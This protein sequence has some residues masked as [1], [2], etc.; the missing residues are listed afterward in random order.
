MLV[1]YYKNKDLSYASRKRFL[2]FGFVPFNQE[3]QKS[4]LLG[5]GANTQIKTKKSNICD[6]VTIDNTRWFVTSYVYCNGGQVIMYLQRDVIGEMGI[7]DC[8]GKIERGY[9]ES[10]LRNRKELSLNQILKERKKL[11]PDSNKYGEYYVDNHKNEMWGIL[12]FVKGNGE[13]TTVN[14]PSFAPKPLSYDFIENGTVKI[15][16][17]N[18]ADAYI[19]FKVH[20]SDTFTDY[21]YSVNLAFNINKETKE[22]YFTR[23]V[24]SIGSGDYVAIDLTVNVKLGTLANNLKL[25]GCRKIVEHYADFIGNKVLSAGYGVSFKLPDTKGYNVGYDALDYDGVI[26]KHD[27]KYLKYTTEKF[28]EYEYGSTSSDKNDFIANVFLF[29]G[30]LSLKVVG[31][32]LGFDME[33][34]VEYASS[35]NSNAASSVVSY[36]SSINFIKYRYNYTVL[37]DEDSGVANIAMTQDLTDEPF[38]V[39]ACPLY[40]VKITGDE[41][42]DVSRDNA[43]KIFNN[44]IEDLSGENGYIVDAQIYPYCPDLTGVS[45]KVFDFPF[46]YVNSTSYNRMCSVN[47]NP[48]TDI[49]K[50][51]IQRSYS[52]VSPE[53]SGKFSFNFY[54]YKTNIIKNESLGS[55]IN[56]EKL[57]IVVKTSLKPFGLISSAVIIPDGDSIHGMTYESDLRGCQPSGNGFQCSLSSNAFETYKRQNSNYQQI[58]AL[59]KGELEMQHEV[60]KV[61]ETTSAVIQTI[62]A[63]AMGAMAGSAAADGFWGDIVHAQAAGAG[64]GA[65]LA[66]GTVGTAMGIQSAQNEKL[67]RYER[68][69]QQQNFDLQIGTIKNLPNSINRVSSFN[70]ILL[71]DFCYIVEIYE[72]SNDEKNIVN[73]FVSKYSYGIGVFDFIVNY[74]KN[75]WFLRSTLVSSS[76][77]SN[78]HNIASNEFMGGIYIYE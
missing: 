62:T 11:V 22:W 3:E 71:K 16:D 28:S 21:Y 47:L 6:Y 42:F 5:D 34:D 64:T 33:Y 76:F 53:Q 41:N 27:D 66:A 17:I 43:F 46:F 32:N 40:D 10:V 75:G 4:I 44:V 8:Y 2:R 36:K 59:Q 57:S 70:E 1:K 14:I 7:E 31:D 19:N 25:A 65:A 35:T 9:T 56:F 55:D 49:K 29:D 77:P 61:N 45:F 72:C 12:Y 26:I 67:R 23:S 18:F 24:A 68:N 54:D 74:A 63:G 78:L 50:E 51:Y 39:L 52:I 73:E 13:T 38:I 58:F 48:C 37:S 60:E 69:L 15:N 20:L 30:R